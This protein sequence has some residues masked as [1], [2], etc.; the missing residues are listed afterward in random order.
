MPDQ[1]QP[2]V[3]AP[4]VIVFDVNETL[5][6]L[7]GLEPLFE[8][9]FGEA[10]ALQDWFNQLLLYAQ[11]VTLAGLYVAFPQLGAGTLRMLGETR[12]IAIETSDLNELRARMRDLAPHDDVVPA[13]QRLRGAGLRLVTLS[14]SAPDP[15]GG[16][17]ERSGLDVHFER[18]FSVDA[19]HRY[20]PAPETYRHV[21]AALD[22]APGELCLVAAH[23]WDTIG[24]QAAGWMAALVQRPGHAALRLPGVPQP[25]I[26]SNGL[27]G[28]ADQII[29]R[30]L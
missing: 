12:G 27:S 16:P 3:I 28:V 6:D 20:K 26:V 25:E 7:S 19:V 22:V 5:L 15:Q 13:L 14:N 18:M 10:R 21:A 9:L 1:V 4:S 2:S 8:R 30:R 23:G 11:S 24:A 17:L 29:R